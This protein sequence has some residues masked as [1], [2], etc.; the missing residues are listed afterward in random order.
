MAGNSDDSSYE[1]SLKHL[2][3]MVL[4]FLTVICITIE[5]S[6]ACNSPPRFYVIFTKN[7]LVS[8]NLYLS[9]SRVKL[10]Q[11]MNCAMYEIWFLL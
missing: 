2:T 11:R 8:Q 6:F 7:G 5:H 3:N 9:Q 4:E 1:A 10:D